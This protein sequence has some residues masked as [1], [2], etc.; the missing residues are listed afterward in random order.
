MTK[1]VCELVLAKA[2]W[3]LCYDLVEVSRNRRREIVLIGRDRAMVTRGHVMLA[4][5]DLRRVLRAAWR[6]EDRRELIGMCR[7]LCR[8]RVLD[9]RRL[10]ANELGGKV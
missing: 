3:S 1:A 5:G 9:Y 7:V 8:E 6:E 2:L 4:A 10:E